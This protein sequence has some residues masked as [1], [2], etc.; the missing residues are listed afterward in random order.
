MS[1]WRD[2][3]GQQLINTLL[4]YGASLPRIMA[5]ANSSSARDRDAAA[6]HLGSVHRRGR[7]KAHHHRGSGDAGWKSTLFPRGRHVSE[8]LGAILRQQKVP[9][10]WVAV[11]VDNSETIVARIW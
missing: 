9:S 2:L 1:S 7:R 8:R 10:D 4:P 11:I 3:D 5:A 6:R